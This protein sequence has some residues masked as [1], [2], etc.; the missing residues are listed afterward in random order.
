MTDALQSSVQSMG[1][2]GEEYVYCRA[3]LLL[4]IGQTSF[5]E[6]STLVELKSIFSELH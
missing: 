4:R 3:S 6:N 2:N 1:E 5:L